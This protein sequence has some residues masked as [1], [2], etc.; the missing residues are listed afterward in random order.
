MNNAKSRV[1][2]GSAQDS[3]AKLIFEKQSLL[4]LSD[5][6]TAYTLSSPWVSGI[7]TVSFSVYLRYYKLLRQL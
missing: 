3:M 2:R 6:E 4:G 7:G 1:E 5:L